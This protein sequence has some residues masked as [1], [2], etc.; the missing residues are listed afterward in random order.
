MS[1]C[2]SYARTISP[3]AVLREPRII[4]LTDSPMRFPKGV[5]LF[6][7]EEVQMNLSWDGRLLSFN[8][9]SA[10]ATEP[11]SGPEKYKTDEEAWQALES[12]LQKL[13][14]PKDLTDRRLERIEP[15]G[16]DYAYSFELSPRPHGFGSQGGNS[17]VC[18][19]QRVTGRVIRLGIS[20]GWTYEPPNVKVTK[21]QAIAN[22]SVLFPAKGESWSAELKYW[23]VGNPGAPAE[24]REMYARKLARL[25]YV[26]TRKKYV[27]I[28][29]KRMLSECVL[30]D[31]V[32]GNVSD[33]GDFLTT[34]ESLGQPSGPQPAV[35]DNEGNWPAVKNPPAR[36]QTMWYA[37]G[38]T[39]ASI[40]IVWLVFRNRRSVI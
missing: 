12:M 19:L 31:A 13:D 2:L 29:A 9:W 6:N 5:F 7:A 35:S 32:T 36:P 1:Q 3:D 33:S 30:V 27:G 34:F 8:D 25:H 17:V 4:L 18:W 16:T 21:E 22:A 39:I 23:A 15:P 40:A 28:P 14:V 20:R 38:A 24:L 10:Q 11:R 26:V 37:A